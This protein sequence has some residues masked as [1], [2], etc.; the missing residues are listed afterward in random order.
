MQNKDYDEIGEL[1]NITSGTDIKL[2]KL[3]EIVRNIVGLKQEIEYDKTKP[4]GTFRKLMDDT[5]IKSLGWYPKIEL[6]DGIQKT[7]EWYQSTI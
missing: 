3:Y 6:E 5:K 2:S 4:N 7:Y 1:V